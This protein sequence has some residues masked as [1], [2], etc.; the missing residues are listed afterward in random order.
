MKSWNKLKSK[1]GETVVETLVSMVGVTLAMLMLA[2][3]IVSTTQANREA[4][5]ATLFLT[6]EAESAGTA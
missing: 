1:R 4:K 2:G 5:D 6:P 3:S